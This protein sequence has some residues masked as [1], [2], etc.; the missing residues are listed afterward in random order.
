M[1]TNSKTPRTKKYLYS[2]DG[3]LDIPDEIAVLAFC[4][5]LELELNAA[6]ER[7]AELT[8]NQR[9]QDSITAQVM[10]RAEKAEAEA[11]VFKSLY[12]NEQGRCEA[13]R[14]DAERYRHCLKHGFPICGPQWLCY[15]DN[16]A[17]AGDTASE[18]I[19][20]ARG[21]NES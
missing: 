21:K 16:G 2:S 14:E 8:H 10:E 3:M 19:D 9:I 18:V 4:Q 12:L 20:A 13:L 6:N 5:Q 1:S 7:I 17:F 11:E 15:G